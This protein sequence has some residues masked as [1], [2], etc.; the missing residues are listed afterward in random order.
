[1][2]T[3]EKLFT[4]TAL[5]SEKKLVKRTLKK[6]RKAISDSD[7]TKVFDVNGCRMLNFGVVC[8][9]EAFLEIITA[10]NGTRLY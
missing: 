2:A 4:I 7:K 6:F 8:T 1:M 5:K 3:Q 9:E 10:M